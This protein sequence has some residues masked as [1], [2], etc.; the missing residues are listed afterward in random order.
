MQI[1]RKQRLLLAGC[2]LMALAISGCASMSESECLSTDW[3]TVG[4]EDGVA[5]YS[6]DR[7]G[8][9]RK[10]CGKHGIAPD[11]SQYQAGRDMG[12]REFCKPANGFRVGVRGHGY[13][14][15]CPADLDGDFGRLDRN[16][17]QRR[18]RG[19]RLLLKGGKHR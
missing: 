7:I 14:G 18:R 9:Y 11:L 6:G 5:G 12:L 19:R 8:S 13:N 2:A 1:T 4:Y 16:F 15:V 3:R 10:A 17:G